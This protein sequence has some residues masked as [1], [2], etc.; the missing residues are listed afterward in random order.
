MNK[1]YKQKETKSLRNHTPLR[2][3]FLLMTCLVMMFYYNP[4]FADDA[5]TLEPLTSLI[6][7]LA[8][9]V[10]AVIA[11]LKAVKEWQDGAYV[12]MVIAIAVGAFL[13]WF[14]S[15]PETVL[16]TGKDIFSGI[17]K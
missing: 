6:L 3:A 13:F 15:A 5:I 1:H 12:K 7:S 17:F 9:S 8:G 10:V 16:N 11:V 2:L 4:V 14:T